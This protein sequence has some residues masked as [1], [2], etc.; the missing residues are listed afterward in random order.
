MG[1]QKC[2]KK[3]LVWCVPLRDA[4]QRL[5]GGDAVV[6]GGGAQCTWGL[7]ACSLHSAGTVHALAPA[8]D[9]IPI[10]ICFLRRNEYEAG[11]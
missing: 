6:L 5:D 1:E 10:N 9:W 11:R 2:W 8:I 4:V 3:E 7:E